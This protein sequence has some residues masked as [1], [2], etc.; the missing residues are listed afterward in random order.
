MYEGGWGRE[1]WKNN[2]E[3]KRNDIY[4]EFSAFFGVRFCVFCLKVYVRVCGSVRKK[5]KRGFYLVCNY[6]RQY[7]KDESSPCDS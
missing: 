3:K 2:Y 1:E 5:R 7:R 4:E 6:M